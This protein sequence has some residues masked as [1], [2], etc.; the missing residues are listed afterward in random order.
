MLTWALSR[1]FGRSKK[2]HPVPFHDHS[3]LALRNEYSMAAT[4][5]FP[6]VLCAARRPSRNV[7]FAEWPIYT[8]PKIHYNAA[9]KGLPLNGFRPHCPFKNV[10]Y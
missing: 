2:A 3:Q 9:A 6:K 8:L 4:C 1:R 7:K 10:V 5:Q